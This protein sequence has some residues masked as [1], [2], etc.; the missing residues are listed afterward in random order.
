MAARNAAY[1]A[2][3]TSRCAQ[4]PQVGPG[5]LRDFQCALYEAYLAADSPTFEDL[6]ADAARISDLSPAPSLEIIRTCLD[7][8]RL[9]A[10]QADAAPIPCS[11]RVGRH[12]MH[13]TSNC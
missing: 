3:R 10:Q 7:E 1:A 11:W 2:R 6:A 12:G 13:T 9:P 8:A 5:P 4:A